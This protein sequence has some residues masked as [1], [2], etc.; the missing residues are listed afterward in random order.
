MRSIRNRMKQFFFLLVMFACFNGTAQFSNAVQ[1]EFQ[2]VLDSFNSKYPLIGIS[3]AIQNANS[4]WTGTNGIS[5]ATDSINSN[6]KFAMGS[7]SKTITSATI[8]KMYE[9][10]LLELSDTVGQYLGQIPWVSPSITIKQLLN[11][12]SGL[13]NY[14]QHP[15]FMKTVFYNSSALLSTTDIFNKFMKGSTFSPGQSWQ[16]SNTNYILLGMIV[17]HISG[18]TYYQEARERFSFT[19]KY[20]SLHLSPFELSTDSLAH[21][22]ID[23]LD[24]GTYF[25][26]QA[27]AT[28]TNAL[29]SSAGAAGAYVATPS[30]LA[31]W[32]YDLYHGKI[33]SPETMLE[34]K[35]SVPNSDGYGLGIQIHGTPCSLATN[36]HNGGIFYRSSTYYCKEKDIAVSIHTNDANVPVNLEALA[37][38]LFC[39][40]SGPT[41][42]K[43]IPEN[44]SFF[45]YPNPVGDQLT[46]DL[47]ASSHSQ[48]NL[49]I[50]DSR[51]QIVVKSE[52]VLPNALNQITLQNLRLPNGIYFL[53]VQ[54]KNSTQVYKF[55]KKSL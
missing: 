42:L 14:T 29:F 55:I 16:Y 44:E 49:E 54:T 43:D 36:G 26:M 30:D 15:D 5:T 13:F 27:S 39:I 50:K 23:T 48:L 31:Q 24:N 18:K 19:V 40:Y 47:N 46:I 21:L 8:L 7:V 22:W 33:L 3:V 41:N 34:L 52:A 38:D 6:H 20:P 28:S 35:D 11:H 2:M 32:A 1:N 45:I 10:G 9:E 17:E 51:G 25:D 53:S 37:N 4:I 12:T